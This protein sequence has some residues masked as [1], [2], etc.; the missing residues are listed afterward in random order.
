[1]EATEKELSAFK[2][3]VTQPALSLGEGDAA[4]MNYPPLEP[5]S[6]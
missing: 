1:M 5:N 6:R 2:T 4:I 3:K